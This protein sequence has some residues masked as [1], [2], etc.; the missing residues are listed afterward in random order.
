MI[1]HLE[2]HRELT[3]KDNLVINLK[4]QLQHEYEN[5]FDYTPVTFHVNIPDG[6]QSSLE[7]F[8]K[9]FLSFYYVLNS[10][11]M[12]VMFLNK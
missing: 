7:Q 2:G 10:T 12:Q 1:N 4:A 5:L 11:K 6:K 8:F 9:K 3:T